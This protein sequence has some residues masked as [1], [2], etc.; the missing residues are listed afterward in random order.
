[1]TV[2]GF[3]ESRII[4]IEGATGGVILQLHSD[5]A[6]ELKAVRADFAKGEVGGHVFSASVETPGSFKFVRKLSVWK[7]D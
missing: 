5:L 7:C 4:P 1:M 6:A 3:T 2:A